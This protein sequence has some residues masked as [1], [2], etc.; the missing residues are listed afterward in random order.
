MKIVHIFINIAYTVLRLYW[1]IFKPK[2]YGVR[3]LIYNKD[4]VLLIKQTYGDKNLLLIPGG[5][6]SPKKEEPLEAILREVKEELSANVEQVEKIGIYTTTAEGKYD[7]V[8]LFSGTV[9]GTPELHLQRLEVSKAFWRDYKTALADPN[10]SN[11]ARQAIT[12]HFKK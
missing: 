11:V 4:H 7:T 12:T 10:L 2:T 3:M 9:T 5:G 6:Y 1:K 8:T